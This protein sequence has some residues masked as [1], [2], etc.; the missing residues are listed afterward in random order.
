M[1]GKTNAIIKIQ[2]ARTWPKVRTAP[3]ALLEEKRTK[4]PIIA[5]TVA[6]KRLKKKHIS[7]TS[8]VL[9]L[10]QSAGF[11]KKV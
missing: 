3:S 10:N 1:T 11:L 5:K 2:A 9:S 6:R 8:A 7:V 4:Y